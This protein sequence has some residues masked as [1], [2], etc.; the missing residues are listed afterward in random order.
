M[1]WNELDYELQV[2]VIDRIVDLLKVE[3]D[4]DMQDGLIAAVHELEVWSNT[5]CTVMDNSNTYV[6]EAKDPFP[7]DERWGS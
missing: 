4:D 2:K 1:I 5:P 3:D 7:E 6:A